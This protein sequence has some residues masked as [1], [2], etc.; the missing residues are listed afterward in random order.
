MSKLFVLM[1]NQLDFQKTKVG[2]YLFFN[3]LGV[4]D[5][6]IHHKTAQ[7]GTK[8]PKKYHKTP[9]NAARYYNGPFVCR[10]MPLV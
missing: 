5:T 8:M 1:Q 4:G 2:G 6:F 3:M 9:Q 7:D 10:D